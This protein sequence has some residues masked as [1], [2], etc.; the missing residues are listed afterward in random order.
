MGIDGVEDYTEL[1][2]NNG[3]ENIT[4]NADENKI[5]VLGVVT[6]G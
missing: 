3:S 2:L 5:P 4:I 1:T 6:Y